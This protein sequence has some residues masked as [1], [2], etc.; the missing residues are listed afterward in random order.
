MGGL[1]ERREQDGVFLEAARGGSG[2]VGVEEMES[3]MRGNNG[4]GGGQGVKSG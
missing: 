3:E 1:L 2:D 4:G